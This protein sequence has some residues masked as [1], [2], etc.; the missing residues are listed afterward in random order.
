MPSL[1]C[2]STY[3]LLP[4]RSSA[5]AIRTRLERLIACSTQLRYGTEVA[6][7]TGQT[8]QNLSNKLSRD[9]FT[10]KEAE[11]LAKALGCSMSVIFTR[12]DTGESL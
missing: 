6:A 5:A 7:A 10:E 8:R 11:A 3:W 9:N 1:Y 4:L 12:T 2:F